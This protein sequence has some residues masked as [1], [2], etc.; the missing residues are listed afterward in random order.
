MHNKKYVVITCLF[1]I[2]PLFIY[3]FYTAGNS[4]QN[5]KLA[6]I[7]ASKTAI[8]LQ[9]QFA[10]V[11]KECMPAVVVVTTQQRVAVIES[12][13]ADIYDYLYGRGKITYR[14]VPSGQG[15]GFFV[16]PDGYILTNF[17]IVRG[18]NSF[19]VVLYDGAEYTARLIGIDPPSDLALLKIDAKRKFFFLKFADISKLR[20]GYW[21]IAIGA[22]FSLEQT[23]T[24]G[25]VS[26]KKRGVGMNLHENFIQ[27]DASINSGNSG[28]PLLDIHGK[29]IGVNDF[30]LSPSGGNIGLSF[31]ISADLAKRVCNDLMKH[32]KVDRPWL[33]VVMQP[34]TAKQ[35]KSLKILHGIVISGIYRKSPAFKSGLNPGDIILSADGIPVDKARD[36]RMIVFS[37]HPDE[38]I[39]VKILRNGKK[40]TIEIKVERPKF[41]IYKY[42]P[43]RKNLLARSC[44][45]LI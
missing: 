45:N 31:A 38:K 7:P 4:H 2:I 36:L 16:S 26:H 20:I 24:V 34:L 43:D 39:I 19:K 13:Y 32:G 23:V 41:N 14:D 10:H 6:N 3:F 1:L 17:H 30:I 18:Q 35:K 28:G 27:T 44:K 22:P 25:I 11:A 40:D 21:S 15:S 42:Y 29:V 5:S 8:S 33:G 9:D 37:K 12:P